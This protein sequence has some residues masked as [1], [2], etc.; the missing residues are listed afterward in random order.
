M[1]DQFMVGNLKVTK[2]VGQ[3]EIDAF[4]A[5]LPAEKKADVKDVIVALHEKGL[6]DIE[7]V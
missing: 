6:I 3:G 2:L 4:V 5:S 7:E 1:A